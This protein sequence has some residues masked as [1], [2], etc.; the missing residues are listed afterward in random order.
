MHVWMPT[1]RGHSGSDV[2]VE[3][4]VAGL[5]LRGVNVTVEWFD[6]RYEFMPSILSSRRAPDG[7]NV[8]HVNG[9]NGFA[10]R[11]HG[12]P[13][14]VTEHHFV[15]DPGYRPYK[16]FLQHVYHRLVTGRASI[17]S[18]KAADALVVHSRFVAETLRAA[19]TH[20]EP[21]VAPL[22]VDLEHFVPGPPQSPAGGKMRL[23]FVGNTS[24]RKGFD[25]VV[26]LARRL[27]DTVSI[28]CTG[29][30]RG[31][32]GDGL[33][34]NI[35]F[36][37]RLSDADLVAAY[38]DTD[39]ALVPSR[40][41]GFG[42]A[43]LEGMACGKPVLGFACG[44]VEEIVDD[45]RSGLLYRVDDVDG[46]ERGAR[47][48]ALAPAR[49]IEMGAAGRSDAERRFSP[50]IGIDTYLSVYRNVTRSA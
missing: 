30:L 37:G 42:Y 32:G 19:G 4:L 13:L 43:A 26:E 5:R 47:E 34:E 11:N 9:L 12:L 15:L 38:Q 23:L 16:S 48:L 17:R 20:L 40:Y 33:P 46:L 28:S 7:A 29:G 21:T 22:W 41:E 2:F 18:M 49:R 10:F 24:R 3:R 44:S 35:R 27:G 14:V 6:R 1:I 50:G 45:G 25:V 8:I 31:Q 36:L 39:V